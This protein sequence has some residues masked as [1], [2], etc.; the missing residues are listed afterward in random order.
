MSST[1]T[2]FQ[3][4]S[5]LLS[6]CRCAFFEGSPSRTRPHQAAFSPRSAAGT[7]EPGSH[8]GGVSFRAGGA[9]RSK[10]GGKKT[11]RTK[12]PKQKQKNIGCLYMFMDFRYFLLTFSGFRKQNPEESRMKPWTWPGGCRR[13]S[14]H[15]PGRFVQGGL[16]SGRCFGS[17][18]LR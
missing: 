6:R 14:E 12:I 16:P 13:S 4:L 7:G 18:V 1:I 10:F 17:N 5:W 8:Q 3:I 15:A 2:Q 9:K 11:L